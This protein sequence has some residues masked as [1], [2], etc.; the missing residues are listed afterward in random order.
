MRKLVFVLL[1]L[2]PSS[3]FGQS[4][5]GSYRAIF[6]DLTSGRKTIVAEFLVSAERSLSGFIRIDGSEKP[7][8]GAIG[9]N[10]KFEALIERRGNF[11]YSIKGRLD[12]DNKIS[13][14]QRDRNGSG[15]NKKVSETA[16]E[17]TFSKVRAEILQSRS[18]TAADADVADTGNSLLRISHPEV[19]FG[20]NWG[21]FAATVS[22]G[23][24]NSKSLG[25]DSKGSSATIES[26]DHFVVNVTSK[27]EGQQALMITVPIG[28]EKKTVWGQNELR[29]ASYREVKGAQRHTFLTGAT[30]QTSPTFADGKIEIVRQS[31]SQIVFKLTNFKIKKL[32]KEEFVTLDGFI[33]AA[34]SNKAVNL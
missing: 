12:Q 2:L 5:E 7:F 25:A 14:I 6:I 20:A 34:I 15:M 24:S 33:Y 26:L 13:L 11:T 30:F 27:P 18:T 23:R 3:A 28:A 29:S 22:F 4:F 1:L 19:M 17:G 32:N 21:E 16:V 31:E 10:G 9:T 8:N